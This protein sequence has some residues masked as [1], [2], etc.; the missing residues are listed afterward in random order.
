MLAPT[1]RDYAIV[2][3]ISQDMSVIIVYVAQ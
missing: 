3:R 1:T 2:Y